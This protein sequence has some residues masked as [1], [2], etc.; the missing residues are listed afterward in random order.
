[1]TERTITPFIAKMTFGEKTLCGASKMVFCEHPGRTVFGGI[2]MPNISSITDGNWHMGV[3]SLIFVPQKILSW[4]DGLCG[5]S[6]ED[7]MREGLTVENWKEE[8]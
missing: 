6:I 5:W 7:L 8:V 1:M 3:G 4:K 2:A